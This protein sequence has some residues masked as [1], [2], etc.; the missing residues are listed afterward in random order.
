[1]SLAC[2][3]FSGD[4][5]DASAAAH[6]IKTALMNRVARGYTGRDCEILQL[7]LG[8]LDAAANDRYWSAL[9][10]QRSLPLVA[11]ASPTPVLEDWTPS[12]LKTG[13]DG[14]QS[15]LPT[16]LMLA[17]RS[18]C[19]MLGQGRVP[20]LESSWRVLLQN[21]GRQSCHRLEE[22]L[23]EVKEK[24][25]RTGKSAD[26]VDDRGVTDKNSKALSTSTKKV[27]D[28]A[29]EMKNAAG[30]APAKAPPVVPIDSL[31]T[32]MARLPEAVTQLEIGFHTLSAKI[33]WILNEVKTCEDD[34]FVIFSHD[35]AI[36]G[37]LT[38]VSGVDD[39][40]SSRS[41]LMSGSQALDLL[42]IDRWERCVS[43]LI[44]AS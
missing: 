43:H 17:L 44:S 28:K 16:E 37:Y 36:F 42:N 20:D 29:V 12:R 13:L 14:N 6:V 40:G 38:E 3:W 30:I 19:E 31:T 33:N 4:Q 10:K 22:E 21:V 23:W 35:V 34:T 25:K 2:C 18:N 7:C 41:L 39:A 27:H 1:M 11:Y 5:L 24:K 15:T 9:M 26:G 8:H 32:R